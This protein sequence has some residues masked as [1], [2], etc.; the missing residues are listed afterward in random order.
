MAEIDYY[1]SETG[2]HVRMIGL[3]ANYTDDIFYRFI[4]WKIESLS[5]SSGQIKLDEGITES[6]YCTFSGLSSGT[7]YLVK[8]IIYN[9]RTSE[10]VY[11]NLEYTKFCKTVATVTDEPVI[12]YFD[13]K[14]PNKGVKKV[15]SHF[16]F[17]G[18]S[19]D[20]TFL[21]AINGEIIV[22]GTTSYDNNDITLTDIDLSNFSFGTTYT[23]W[24]EISDGNKSATEYFNF[25]LEN[26]GAV[27]ITYYK[28]YDYSCEYSDEHT[29]VIKSPVE[30][31]LYQLVSGCLFWYDSEH[32]NPANYT[33]VSDPNGPFY[34]IIDGSYVY[35]FRIDGVASTEIGEYFTLYLGDTD[36][37]TWDRTSIKCFKYPSADFDYSY[38]YLSVTALNTSITFDFKPRSAYYE[39]NCDENCYYHIKLYKNDGYYAKSELVKEFVLKYNESYTV[40]QLTAG[41]YCYEACMFYRTT[42]SGD[43]YVT[44]GGV[45]SYGDGGVY[46]HW[47]T[48]SIAELSGIHP[49]AQWYWTSEEIYA[50]QN[51]GV[52]KTLTCERMNEF[53]TYVDNM[54]RYKCDTEM[55]ATYRAILDKFAFSD[56]DNALTE[57]KFNA[58][59]SCIGSFNSTYPDIP[60]TVYSGEIVYGSYFLTLS[61]KLNGIE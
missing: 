25:I 12:I 33:V 18:F 39:A 60:E 37:L 34:Q 11:E 9:V 14:Q 41:Y 35:N 3:D 53:A 45:D 46:I 27:R 54:L 42:K 10:G 38:G 15:N 24:L 58:V 30:L 31:T 55:Y 51:K 8:C 13:V 21:I 36:T 40:Q 16:Q 56:N 26:P 52:T 29:V 44:L 5:L 7:S 57:E 47:D 4:E 48:L 1:A 23:A 6:D 20:V 19:S 22:E 28:H 49:F 32:K 59:K 61:E 50:L 17:S 43:V 2:L